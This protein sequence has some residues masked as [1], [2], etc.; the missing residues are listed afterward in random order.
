MCTPQHQTL[1]NYGVD[2]VRLYCKG[3]HPILKV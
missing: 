3:K 1:L 2:Y